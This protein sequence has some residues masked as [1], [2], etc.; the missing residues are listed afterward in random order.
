MGGE[1]KA[2]KINHVLQNAVQ[3]GERLELSKGNIKI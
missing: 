1:K 2:F 3:F